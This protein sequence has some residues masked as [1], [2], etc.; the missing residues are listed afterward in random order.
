MRKDIFDTDDGMAKYPYVRESA[1]IKAM[2]TILEHHCGVENR[3][4]FLGVD[5]SKVKSKSYHDSVGIGH[6]QIDLHPTTEGDN[7]IDFPALPFEL[8]LGSLIP[9][10][11]KNREAP[12]TPPENKLKGIKAIQ[13][14]ISLKF[15]MISP[16]KLIK[17]LIT[18]V[19]SLSDINICHLYTSDASDE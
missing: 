1:R 12:I 13:R 3:A 17:L 15:K 8:P 10:K 2:T 19:F 18:I 5:Q 14:I 16:P 11:I 4:Q 7:Y 9:I 6:Y